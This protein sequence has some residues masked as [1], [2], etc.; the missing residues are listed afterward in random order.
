VLAGML[1]E[2][3]AGEAENAVL[4]PIQA[5]REL[6]PESYAVFIVLPNG[7][8]EMRVVQVGLRDF[9]NAEILSG[10]ESG[11]MISLGVESGSDTPDEAPSNEQESPLGT[12]R[13]FG[14]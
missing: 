14:G 7:E 12:M 1:V 8:L 10:L 6:A 5:L 2:V 4:V 11:E 13:F 3:V 9:V